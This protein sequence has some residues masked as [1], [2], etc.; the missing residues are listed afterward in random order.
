[1]E[2]SSTEASWPFSASVN[3]GMVMTYDVFDLIVPYT[4]V[5]YITVYV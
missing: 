2:V 4:V 1:M 5:T 3:I